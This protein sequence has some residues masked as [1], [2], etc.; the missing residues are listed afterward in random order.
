MS[1][2]VVKSAA[3]V[4]EV[5][6]FFAG[7]KAP[8]TVGEVCASLGYPQSSTSVLLKSLLT[9]GYLSYD[10]TT[11]RYAPSVKVARLGSWITS[12]ADGLNEPS[13]P[14]SSSDHSSPMASL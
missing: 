3:R 14:G 2:T 1:D 13:Q 5:F 11:R 6:E 9:L 4:L 8:A 12:S 7:R 10:G